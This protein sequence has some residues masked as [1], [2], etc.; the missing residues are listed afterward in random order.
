MKKTHAILIHT[1]SN[2]LPS[3]S[4]PMNQ[5]FTWAYEISIKNTSEDI[6]QLLNRYWRVT[7]MSSKIEEIK[8]PGVIG[9]Q[10]IIKPGKEFVYNSFCQLNTPKGTMEGHYEMQDLEE[11]HFIVEIPKFVLMAPDSLTRAYHSKLH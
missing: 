8:G 5:R 6:V 3:Q 10:P 2:Y 1:K 9:L 7:D 11:Q 4:D